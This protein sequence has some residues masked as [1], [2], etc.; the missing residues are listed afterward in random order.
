MVQWG[1]GVLKN[2]HK[3]DFRKLDSDFNRSTK[4]YEDSNPGISLSLV[5]AM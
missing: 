3:G 1:L 5:W 2:A 4:A